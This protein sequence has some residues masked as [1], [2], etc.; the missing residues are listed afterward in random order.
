M[1]FKASFIA[2]ALVS[3]A[4]ACHHD[5]PGTTDPG[6]NGGSNSAATAGG[7]STENSSYGGNTGSGSAPG[8]RF[9]NGGVDP[10]TGMTMD[11]GIP[12]GGASGVH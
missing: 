1:S 3:G 2:F 12:D 10:A 11:A 6:M 4:V 9:T 5:K 7:A 8:D